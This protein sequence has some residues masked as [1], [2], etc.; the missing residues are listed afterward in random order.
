MT[1]HQSHLQGSHKMLTSPPGIPHATI[2][3]IFYK[4]Y[5]IPKGTTVYGNIWAMIHDKKKYENPNVFNP[6][7]FFDK[8]GNLSDN[9]KV[10]AYGFGQSI[11]SIITQG[12]IVIECALTWLVIACMLAGF[13]FS[14]KKDAQGDE[15]PIDD[16][17]KHTGFVKKERFYAFLCDSQKKQKSTE[18]LHKN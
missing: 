12:R 4:G 7:R 10:L 17:V 18:S 16:E 11:A 9:D 8:D 2:E 14:T 15:I 13:Q 3:D 1:L 5:L 6:D